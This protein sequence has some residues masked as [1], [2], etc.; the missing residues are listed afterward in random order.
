[1]SLGADRKPPP[2]TNGW[3][4]QGRCS[5]NL[6]DEDG[7]I[8][9]HSPPFTLL[10]F[11]HIILQHLLSTLL[12]NSLPYLFFVFLTT[13]TLSHT[14]LH[15]GWYVDPADISHVAALTIEPRLTCCSISS[16]RQTLCDRKPALWRCR[17]GQGQG[18]GEEPRRCKIF[19]PS[20]P[21][22]RSSTSLAPP[23]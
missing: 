9:T 2:D 4:L 20:P 19:L 6:R 16:S 11:C 22:S 3:I 13:L 1:M 7:E 10:C 18:P 14:Y 15:D 5:Q 12:R 21:S 23:A 17:Q 8:W